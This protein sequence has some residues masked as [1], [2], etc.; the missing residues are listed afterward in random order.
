MGRSH[1]VDFTCIP[2]TRL[3]VLVCSTEDSFYL[4]ELADLV[5]RSPVLERLDVDGAVYGDG[6]IESNF[7][8][9]L[10]FCRRNPRLWMPDRSIFGPIPRLKHLSVEAH[11]LE[12]EIQHS[13]TSKWWPPL[14]LLSL[15]LTNGMSHKRLYSTMLRHLPDLVGLEIVIDAFYDGC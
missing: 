9:S 6:R 8:T 7:L 10:K 4:K 15:S 11:F 2:G 5:R 14:S 1:H 3:R 12:Y 13:R